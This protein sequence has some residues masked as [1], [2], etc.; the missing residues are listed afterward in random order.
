VESEVAHYS[1]V[2]IDRLQC[3][4]ENPAEDYPGLWLPDTDMDHAFMPHQ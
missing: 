2:G 4:V 1:V 3:L